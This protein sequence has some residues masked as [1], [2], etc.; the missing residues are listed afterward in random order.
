ML[1]KELSPPALNPVPIRELGAHLRLAQGFT[2]DGSEDALLELYLRN[3]TSVI[4]TRCARALIARPFLLQ[5]DRWDRHGHLYLPVGPVALIDSIDLITPTATISL[6]TS[7][8]ALVPGSQR[9]RV[10]GPGGVA[11]PAL[12]G[13]M[14]A[15]LAF[16]A[17]YGPGWNQVPD[18]L[19]QAVLL[20]AAHFYENRGGEAAAEGGM[21]HGLTALLERHRPVRL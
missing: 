10:T 13:G 6:D 1:L 17:G 12:S 15:E 9:Q 19:R 14:V 7:D 2:D 11:L 16:T 5:V 20:L 3:A 21:P 18:D 4:E 8:W